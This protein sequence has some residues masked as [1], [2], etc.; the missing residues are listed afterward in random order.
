MQFN[1]TNEN[2]VN[3]TLSANARDFLQN[4]RIITAKPGMT[5]KPAN[6]WLIVFSCWMI[7][8]IISVVLTFQ[9]QSWLWAAGSLVWGA[10]SIMALFNWRQCV[11]SA[12]V[13]E[14][15][16]AEGRNI[17]HATS[18]PANA[19]CP[20]C[21]SQAGKVFSEASQDHCSVTFQCWYC[22]HGFAKTLDPTS[23]EWK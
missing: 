1:Q 13:M 11:Q 17:S 9:F 21:G 4:G 2:A 6:P 7:T 10:A 22:N 15:P 12:I 23:G 5:Y 14:Y 19:V 3:N 16:T 20:R 18:A 8:A